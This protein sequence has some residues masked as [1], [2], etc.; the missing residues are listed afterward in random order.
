M[1]SL[2]VLTPVLLLADL[3]NSPHLSVVHRHPLEAVLGGV[4]ALAVL[5]SL[6]AV[7][8]RRPWLV[9][10]LVVLTLPFRIPIS[11]G[12]TTSNLLIPLYVV[13]AAATLAYV[14][15][16]FGFWDRRRGP[17]SPVGSEG[18]ATTSASAAEGAPTA[19]A[20]ATGYPPM[21]GASNTESSATGG[22]PAVAWMERLLVAYV[23]LYAVQA[24]YS[25]DFQ[26]ALQQVVFFYVPFGL[27]YCVLRELR[28]E[29]A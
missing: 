5:I 8:A 26:L 27:G 25:L 28:W 7:I 11:T 16:E 12:G 4:L 17:E 29:P 18:A 1:L 21:T 24:T 22:A 9:A 2:I 14:G 19:G 10:L 6:A 15:S 3:W 13:L 23:V 20:S